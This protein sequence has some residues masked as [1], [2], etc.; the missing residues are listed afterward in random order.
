[1]GSKRPYSSVDSTGSEGRFSQHKK[2]KSTKT[3]EVKDN[4]I[5]SAKK[6]ARTIERRLKKG[7]DLPADVQQKLE[8]ELAAL[9]RRV[10]KVQGRKLRQKMISKYHM[11]R[12]FGKFTCRGLCPLG[13]GNDLTKG[14][15]LEK[16]KAQRLQKQLRKRLETASLEEMPEIK[17]N[18]HICEVDINYTVYFPYLEP[19]ISLYPRANAKSETAEDEKSTAASSLQAERPPLWKVVEEAMKEGKPAL[20][21]LRDRQPR[22]N[23]VTKASVEPATDNGSAKAKREKSTKRDGPVKTRNDRKWHDF[24]RGGRGHTQKDE[25]NESEGS[26]GDGG[27]FFEEM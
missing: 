14:P 22:E 26:N 24:E 15:L 6:R 3:Y 21:R 1:M 20:E 2:R 4:S 7:D 9:Q 23:S 10:E 27:G 19:Y 13:T 5:N 18:L 11:V 12:F 8:R 16:K 17:R 25:A